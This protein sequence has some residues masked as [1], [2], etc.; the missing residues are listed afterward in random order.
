MLY[1]LVLARGRVIDPETGLDAVRDVGLNGGSV[2][3]ISE[4]DLSGAA[5]RVLDCTGLIVAPGFID[6]HSHGMKQTDS[7]LQACDGVTTHLELEFGCWPVG[8]FYDAIEAEGSAINFGCSVGHI[9]T[10]VAALEQVELGFSMADPCCM[11][12]Q[13]VT[14]A[15]SHTRSAT[16]AELQTLMTLLERGITEGGIGVGA[17]IAYTPGSDHRE[18]LRLQQCCARN[19]VA[20]FIHMRGKHD[21]GLEDFHEVFT[22]AAVTGCPLHIC[23]ITPMICH[24]EAAGPGRAAAELSTIVG[25]ARKLREVGVDITMEAYP[26]T[27]GMTNID[28]QIFEGELA[29]VQSKFPNVQMPQAMQW[30][31]TGEFL[32][33]ETF[34][35]YREETART[36]AKTFSFLRHFCTKIILKTII[37]PRQ[38]GDKHRENS[39]KGASYCR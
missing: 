3:A 13:K 20:L 24:V 8:A 32:T 29:T 38:A 31:D 21:I 39:K 15:A 36:G 9:P 35:K 27:A 17:G 10:R 12:E 5:A 11:L 16:D 19:R 28:S 26:Y 4:A 34:F 25:M 37:L 14:G 33:E 6:I 1:E 22:N 2:A 23:H 7:E 30:L 18:V